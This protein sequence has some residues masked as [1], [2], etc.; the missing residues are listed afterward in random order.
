VKKGK[1]KGGKF[2]KKTERGKIEEKWKIM[3]KK[4]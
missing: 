1:R 2:K 4:M 3:V